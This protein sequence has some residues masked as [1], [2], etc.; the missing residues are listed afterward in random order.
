MFDYIQS[1]EECVDEGRGETVIFWRGE[2]EEVDI[3]GGRAYVGADYGA[4]SLRDRD[5]KE[6]GCHCL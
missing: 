4:A 1:E 6:R 3:V 5:G 2:G